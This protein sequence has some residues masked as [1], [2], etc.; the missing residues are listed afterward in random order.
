MNCQLIQFYTSID[1]MRDTVACYG[2]PLWREQF[3]LGVGALVLMVA[4]AAFLALGLR[5]LVR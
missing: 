5:R 4:V 2:G 3:T 1:Q